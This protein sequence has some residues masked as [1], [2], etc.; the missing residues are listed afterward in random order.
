M[1]NDF[2]LKNGERYDD[3]QFQNLQLIQKEGGYTFT[4]DAVLIA[5]RVRAYRGERVADLGTG[6]GVIAILVAAKTPC[7][8]VVGVEI[9]PRLADMASRSVEVN[10]LSDRVKIL[11]CNMLDAPER[12]GKESFDVVVSNPPYMLA[13]GDSDDEVEICKREYKITLREVVGTAAELLKYGGNLY[14]ILKSE[15]LTD[16]IYDMRAEGVEPKRLIPVQPTAKKD[17]DTVI[18]EGK[19][20]GKPGMVMEKPLVVFDE[21]GEYTLDAKRLYDLC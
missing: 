14:M 20:A 17:I 11:E 19:K 12:L 1:Y 10:G 16:L 8:E 5:N 9:Q 21:K 6:S 7:K 4:S 15:R 18:V 13:V 3:L 2:M